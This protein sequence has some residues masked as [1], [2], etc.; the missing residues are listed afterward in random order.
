MFRILDV[1]LTYGYPCAN[2]FSSW[3]PEVRKYV[4]GGDIPSQLDGIDLVIF[5]GG[6]DIS[7][8]I[9]GHTNV[10][11]H[12]GDQPSAR[13]REEIRL[14]DVLMVTGKPTLGICR[15]AQFL[16]AMTGGWLVQH[17]DNHAGAE[18]PVILTRDPDGD[19]VVI[20]NS[21]HHQMMV[22]NEHS[23]VLGWTEPL[24]QNLTYDVKAVG[25]KND[26]GLEMNA[27]I[28][29]F[30]FTMLGFQSHPEYFMTNHKLSRKTRRYVQHYLKVGREFNE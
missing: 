25:L 16:C 6:Q 8:S 4:P 29:L 12:S 9:Y 2:I 21:Y 30:N 11:S 28:V 24:A 22:P 14:F 15:G 19:D 18:H 5:G 27:E 20:A 13:D 23:K 17:V 3:N 26:V 7:P 1:G 10:A